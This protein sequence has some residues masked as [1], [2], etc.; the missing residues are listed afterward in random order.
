[1]TISESSL[2]TLTPGQLIAQLRD[3]LGLVDDEIA[4]AVGADRRSL[5]A[6]VA[7]TSY[8]QR[9]RRQRLAELGTLRSHLLQDFQEVDAVRAWVQA[10]NGYLRGI[11]HVEAIVA[12]RI[13]AVEAA[14]E[15]L[16]SGV[17]I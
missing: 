2:L 6:W 3:D 14:A 7:G 9:A 17:F 4:R 16:A 12:G 5:E 10:P 8:P 15:A 1:M 13:D 11:R